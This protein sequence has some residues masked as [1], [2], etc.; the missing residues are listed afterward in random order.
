MILFCSDDALNSEPVEKEWTA[1]EIM[2]EPII[3]VFYN[4]KHI[5]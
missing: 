4:T 2:G 1:A 5:F 3:P